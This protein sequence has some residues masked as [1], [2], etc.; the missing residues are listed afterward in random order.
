MNINSCLSYVVFAICIVIGT[1]PKPQIVPPPEPPQRFALEGLELVVSYDCDGA[2]VNQLR[3][4][5]AGRGR[6]PTGIER[7]DKAASWTLGFDDQASQ[8]SKPVRPARAA[9]G[10][11][12]S[13]RA[14][15]LSFPDSGDAWS[16]VILRQV[17]LESVRSDLREEVSGVRPKSPPVYRVFVFECGRWA[18]VRSYDQLPR[19]NY[20]PSVFKD[21]SIVDRDRGL[22]HK[23]LAAG[24]L[25]EQLPLDSYVAGHPYSIL[26]VIGGV[27]IAGKGPDIYELCLEMRKMARQGGNGRGE[28]RQM[29]DQLRRGEILLP[30]A[31]EIGDTQYAVGVGL[32]RASIDSIR[33]A[34]KRYDLAATDKDIRKAWGVFGT[35][36]Q[37]PDGKGRTY[38]ALDTYFSFTDGDVGAVT[39]L[40]ERTLGDIH[41]SDYV[42]VSKDLASGHRDLDAMQGKDVLFRIVESEWIVLSF[43]WDDYSFWITD[44]SLKKQRASVLHA[45]TRW[46]SD[47][48]QLR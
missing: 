32:F 14:V 3:R 46:R 43:Y 11:T 23:P 5:L 17:P 37:G 2:L 45:L 8:E 25:A 20:R 39:R 19:A 13:S 47:A 41:Y 15:V 29:L 9:E 34:E 44:S 12:A 28:A 6:I 30:D 4:V 48:Q 33:E 7:R 31:V 38:R 18:L 36:F 40:V 1:P 26:P 35:Y 10:R 24:A 21:Q 22:T 16:P 42:Q 27:E